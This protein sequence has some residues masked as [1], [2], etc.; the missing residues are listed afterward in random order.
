MNGLT[1]K[2]EKF[3]QNIV[4]GMTQRQAYKESYNAENMTDESI[5]VE[6]CKLFNDTKVAQ[7]YRELLEELKDVAIMSAIE[8]MKF[9]TDIVKEK[10]QED[11][12]M[13]GIPVG[14]TG[15]D[16]N[17][18]M[19]AIDILNKMSGEYIT[20]VEAAVNS[21]VNINIELSDD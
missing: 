9:L 18:K 17:T 5:D 3:I 4:S 6:A 2:Q 19:K 20:K 12:I 13:N 14:K 8:R 7:R 11:L 1:P 10:E 21:E 15:A 16:L